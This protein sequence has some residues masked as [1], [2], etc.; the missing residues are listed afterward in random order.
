MAS[1][2]HKGSGRGGSRKRGSSMFMGIVIGILL[3]LIAAL[4]V[5][6]Y[7]NKGP[8]PFTDKKP[9]EA[10]REDV[11]AKPPKIVKPAE[12]APAAPAAPAQ[13]PA[14]AGAKPRFEFYGILQGK[15]EAIKDKDVK[16]A[17]PKTVYYIQAGAFQNAADADN[18]KAKLALAGVEAAIQT[19]QLPDGKTWHRVRLGP[20]TN[21]EDIDKAKA[22]LKEN[23]IEGQ[24][25]KM[26][27]A[28]PKS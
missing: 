18:L 3:G 27:D 2:D 1:Q 23:Q 12:P 17:A 25:I 26:K 20:F 4:G 8:S 9:S 24:L 15:E 16:L 21:V 14:A 5:A 10:N 13:P 11:P 6:L 22:R 7:I 28:A 19:A